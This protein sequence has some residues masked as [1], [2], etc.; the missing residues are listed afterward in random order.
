MNADRLNAALAKMLEAHK[1]YIARA[2]EIH[3]KS[4]DAQLAAFTAATEKAEAELVK[5]LEGLT[6]QISQ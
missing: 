5:Q 1:R 6:R 2:V 4:I 3:E